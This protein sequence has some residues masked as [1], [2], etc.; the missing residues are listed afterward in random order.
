MAAGGWILAM[1]LYSILVWNSGFG[2]V[3][4][5]FYFGF[6]FGNSFGVQPWFLCCSVLVALFFGR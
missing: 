1:V 3:F 5:L 4:I 2:V 6:G